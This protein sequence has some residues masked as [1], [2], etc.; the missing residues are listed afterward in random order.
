MHAN[1]H[2]NLL[3]C[4]FIF[5][6][7][8]VRGIDANEAGSCM[9]YKRVFIFIGMPSNMMAIGLFSMFS[10]FHGAP[11]R[12]ISLQLTTAV[13]VSIV[14][15]IIFHGAILNEKN[16]KISRRGFIHNLQRST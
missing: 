7:V 2:E 5:I 13:A 3:T 12:L 8:A 9:K 11:C 4:T 1:Q 6:T 15:L 16:I 10:R 14:M